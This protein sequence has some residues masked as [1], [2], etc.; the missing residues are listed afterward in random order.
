[1]RVLYGVACRQTVCTL[2][3]IRKLTVYWFAECIVDA[4]VEYLI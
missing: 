3:S 2:H 1:M 4:I